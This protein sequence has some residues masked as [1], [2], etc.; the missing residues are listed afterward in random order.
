M[1]VSSM[2]TSFSILLTN[3]CNLFCDHCIVDA[4][5]D[6]DMM[7]DYELMEN[8]I[9]GMM[10]HDL[11]FIGI[12]GGEPFLFKKFLKQICYD[13]KNA[14]IASIIA[15]NAFWAST[16]QLAISNLEEMYKIGLRKII[17]SYD[18]Y[19]EK[20]IPI[21]NIHHAT[22]AAKEIG[23]YFDIFVTAFEINKANYYKKLLS[24]V[25][26]ENIFLTVVEKAGR[27]TTI[28]EDD[29][30]NSDLDY[31]LYKCNKL[32]NPILLFSGKVVACCDL[33]VSKTYEPEPGSLLCLGN[34]YVCVQ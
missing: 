2:I 28:R 13:F 15:T 11:K 23:I 18:Q 1:N 27:A 6:G 7:F 32:E 21:E 4:C 33:L 34:I 3:K 5:P 29:S 24:F 30:Y 16:Y 26:D 22:K 17:L 9:E 12:S 25:S 8:I 31:S 14:G 20:Y 10:Y 19:H